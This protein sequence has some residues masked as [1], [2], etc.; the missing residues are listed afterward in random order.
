VRILPEAPLWRL[1]RELA[2]RDP[3]TYDYYKRPPAT[4][5]GKM[6]RRSARPASPGAPMS[7]RGPPRGPE[8]ALSPR[9]RRGNEPLSPRQTFPVD[10][11]PMR[12]SSARVDG[13]KERERVRSRSRA[14]SASFDD[15]ETEIRETMP[16]KREKDKAWWEGRR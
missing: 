7:P 11:R 9:K 8:G 3:K 13:K 1:E 10:D 16:H 15:R 12:R 4:K 14:R 6:S 2:R 5:S